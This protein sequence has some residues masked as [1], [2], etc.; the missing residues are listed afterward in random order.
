MKT[1][2]TSQAVSTAEKT[3]GLH[4]EKLFSQT[5]QRTTMTAAV[6]SMFQAEQ[7]TGTAQ[8]YRSRQTL[9]LQETLTA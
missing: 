9:S 3:N 7:R 4:E 1:A 8:L 6:H 5:I 2:A